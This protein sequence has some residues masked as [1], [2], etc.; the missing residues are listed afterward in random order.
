MRGT[1][2]DLI[3]RQDAEQK[4][5]PSLY[6]ES[7]EDGLEQRVKEA[8]ALIEKSYPGVAAQ[9]ISD[10]CWEVVIPQEYRNGQEAHFGQVTERYLQ[11]LQDGSLPEWEVPNM[12]T[13]YYTTTKALEFALQ[14]AAK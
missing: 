6:I 13:K 2:A 12:I 1:K 3:I 5:I 14:K 4:Y 9:K 11:Y 7:K 10:S 8:V